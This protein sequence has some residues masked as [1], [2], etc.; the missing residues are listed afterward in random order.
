[1]HSIHKASARRRTVPTSRLKSGLA[2]LAIGSTAIFLTACGGDGGDS[3]PITES[4]APAACAALSG[5]TVAASAIGEPSTGAVVTSATFTAAVPDALNGAGTAVVQGLPNY[6]KLLV[7]IKPVDPAAPL[8]KV[9]VNLPT[10]WNGKKLQL[11][12]SGFNGTLV[13]GLGAVHNAPADTPLPLTRGYMTA[14]TDSGHQTGAGFEAQAF[15]LNAEALSNFAYASYKNTHDVAVQMAQA[16]YNRKPSRSYYFGGS[17]G[18]REGMT[19]AQRYP[20]DFDGIFAVDPVMNWS[21][22]QTFGNWV[23]GI[24]QQGAAWLGAPG[25]IQL[26]HDTVMGACDAI[27]GIADSVVSAYKAC[28]PLADAALAAKRCVSGN[29]EGP[30]CL[31]DAQL[32]AVNAAHSGYSFNFPLANGVTSYAGF[33]YGG[34]GLAGNW[35]AWMTGTVPPTFTAAPN[36]TGLGQLFAFGNQYVRYFI[37]QNKDFNPLNYNPDNFQAR[38]QAVSA[39]MDAT[40]PD[41]SAYRGRGGKLIL[42]EDLADTAQ[43]PYT[44]LNYFEAVVAKMGSSA[45]DSFMRTYVAPGLPHT[46]NG[47]AAAAVNA[48]SY[49]IPG[50]FDW[51]GAMDN[52]VE[53]GTPPADQITAVNTLAVAPYTVVA[54]KPFCR[55][56]LYP[57]YGGTGGA[58]GSAA[59]WFSCSVQ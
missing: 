47:I 34:E 12:G 50:R 28:K 53:A 46:S 48:P 41:L 52:W 7:D 21:G 43:S 17:E 56:P 23:G 6:C 30:A 5:R 49:G 51:L 59:A 20:A 38:V 8:T 22:L 4:S 29:D 57:K 10:S 14:G 24:R 9:Q 42:K 13:T 27:D 26:V 2:G 35:S 18:G 33:G 25:K 16:Y 32:A 3:N 36:A 45:V 1:M 39:Q 11:G 37:A 40:N 55:Y 31:S 54:S 58:S 19:M 44:G 15:A